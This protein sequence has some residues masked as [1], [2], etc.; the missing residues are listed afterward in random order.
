MGAMMPRPSQ[1][2]PVIKWAEALARLI[3]ENQMSEIRLTQG[4]RKLRLRRR[5]QPFE[6]ARAIS[7]GT[8]GASAP[9]VNRSL[10]DEGTQ[11]K[12]AYVG[13]FRLVHPKTAKPMT[14]VDDTAETNQVLGW[15]EVM[16][17]RHE[18]VA[19]RAGTVAALLVDEGEP[20]E[21]GQILLILQ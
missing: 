10:E 11:I 6:V 14:A 16:G 2:N 8:P 3:S 18:V 1:A 12:S 7:G 13:I 17:I 21:Y 20:V 5:E 15:V 19:P 4:E 9:P